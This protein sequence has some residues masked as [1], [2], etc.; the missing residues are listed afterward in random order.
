MPKFFPS[1][2]MII[3]IFAKWIYDEYKLGND[4]PIPA[5]KI[6]RNI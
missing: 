6:K 1:Q 3:D 4:I 5:I 2:Q